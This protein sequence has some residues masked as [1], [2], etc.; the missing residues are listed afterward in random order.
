MPGASGLILLSNSSR[1]DESSSA[2]E[3]GTVLPFN[4]LNNP[5]DVA[6]DSGGNVYVSDTGNNRV[7]RLAD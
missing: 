2:Q 3:D 6:V 5:A 4:G 1:E 7:V